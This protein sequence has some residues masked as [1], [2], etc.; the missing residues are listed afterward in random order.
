MAHI[1][2]IAWWLI[3][4]GA[5]A[6][7][8]P[9]VGPLFGFGMGPDPA[10]AITEAR[11]VRHVIPGTAVMLGGWM[12]LGRSGGLRLAGGVVALLGAAWQAV[13]PFMLDTEGASQFIRRSVYH[14][15]TG[16]VL[17]FL[18]AFALGVLAGRKVLSPDQSG[19]RPPERTTVGA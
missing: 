8:I 16:L 1:R 6:F 11:V 2:G 4:L 17:F 12:L 18:A 13:G 9:F 7:L 10:F 3:G 15:G 19:D 14:S 5:F